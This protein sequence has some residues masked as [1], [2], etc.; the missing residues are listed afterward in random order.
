M[1]KDKEDDCEI[2]EKYEKLVKKHDLPSFEEINN[3]FDITKIDSDSETLIRDV[4]KAITAKFS[5]ILS[6]VEVLLNPTSG[7]MFYMFLV[8]GVNGEEK[9]ILNNLFA[10]IGAMDIEAITLDIVYSEEKEAEFIKSSF[11]DWR[12]IQKDLM[13]V[14][15]KLKENWQKTAIKKDRSYYG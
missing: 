8:K 10:K 11:E 15:D 3:D 5:S 14:V 2:K 7:S 9:E 6:F 1:G 13:K 12:R 4:R